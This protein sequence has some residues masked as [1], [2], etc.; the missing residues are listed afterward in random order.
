MAELKV[1]VANPK[2]GKCYQKVL[3]E[4]IY[5]GMKVKDKISGEDLGL[6]G[7]E[8]EITGGSDDSGCPIRADLPGLG[9]KQVLLT[10]GPCIKMHNAQSGLRKKKTVVANTITNKIVQLNVKII[11]EGSKSVEESWGIAPKESAQPSA[12]DLQQSEKA[13]SKGET[14]KP[15]AKPKPE[16][17]A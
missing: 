7:Y 15:A 10:K 1:V 13:H 17:T 5:A 14:D 9:K 6:E 16:T 8:L 12:S 2:T 3:P 4:N 11:K